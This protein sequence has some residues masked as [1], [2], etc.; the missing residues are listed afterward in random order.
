M[1]NQIYKEK[2]VSPFDASLVLS[3]KVTQTLKDLEFMGDSIDI[4]D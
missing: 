2:G 4:T 3:R 1:E